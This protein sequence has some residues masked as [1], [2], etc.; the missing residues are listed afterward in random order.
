MQSGENGNKGMYLY[1][2]TS[3]YTYLNHKQRKYTATEFV[4]TPT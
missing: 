1:I 4:I 2:Y 3:M